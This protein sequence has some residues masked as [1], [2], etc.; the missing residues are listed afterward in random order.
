MRS[1]VA[2]FLAS[3]ACLAARELGPGT[4][5]D[6]VFPELPAPAIQRVL[7]KPHPAA[8]SVLLPD[9]FDPQEAERP[10]LT[11]QAVRKIDWSR[12]A[13]V[14]TSNGGHVLSF[15]M[16]E[17]GFEA[18]H[19]FR[20]FVFA[21]SGRLYQGAG[22]LPAGSRVRFLLGDQAERFPDNRMACQQVETARPD[23]VDLLLMEGV[24]HE[25]PER[26]RKAVVRWLEE[27]G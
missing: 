3:A 14:G 25:F 7:G 22:H 1:F 2:I 15:W 19:W 26:Y 10:L 23:Q 11:T 6:L 20:D 5:L 17:P 9:D 8:C 16:N 18:R 12:S 27:D 4:R 21:E 24:G 13:V